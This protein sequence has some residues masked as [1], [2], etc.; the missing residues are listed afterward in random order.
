[1]IHV[2]RS[3]CRISSTLQ[4]YLMAASFMGSPVICASELTEASEGYVVDQ[5]D[6]ITCE[7]PLAAVKG[8]KGGNEEQFSVLCG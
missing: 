1:M 4:I 2:C 6:T 5:D 3:I 8:K 7:K